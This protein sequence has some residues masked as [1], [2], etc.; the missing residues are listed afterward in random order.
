VWYS[1]TPSWVDFTQCCDRIA[2]SR[3][4]TTF[5]HI[6][7]RHSADEVLMSVLAYDGDIGKAI[8]KNPNKLLDGVDLQIGPDSRFSDMMKMQTKRKR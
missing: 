2:L 7:A 4:S 8:L 6:V 1:H 3:N 5:T